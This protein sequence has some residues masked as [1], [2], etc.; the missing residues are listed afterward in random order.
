MSKYLKGW[1]MPLCLVLSTLALMQGGWWLWAPFIGT[2]L[3]FVI[4]DWILP[5]DVSEPPLFQSL[6]LNFPL[7]AI[8]PLMALMDFT[9]IW[10]AGSG[11]FL[12]YAEF[13][14]QYLGYDL[15]AARELVNDT[16]MW[17]GGVISVA[18][19]NAYAGTV[20][21]HELTHRTANP[22]D[23]FIGRWMLAFSADTQFAIEHVYGHHVTVATKEDPATARRGESFYAFTVRSTLAGWAHGFELEAQRLRKS[24]RSMLNPF[25]SPYLRGMIENGLLFYAAFLMAGWFGVGLWAAVVFIA[26]QV[27]EIANYFEHY[28]LIREEGKPVEPRHSWNSNHWMS[29]NVMFSLAR[30]SH[31]HAEA[32]WPY[33][34]LRA[35]P[36]APVLP[37]GYVTMILIAL[38]PPLFKSIM[39]PALNAWDR[40]HASPGELKLA[41]QANNDSGM[42]GL[43]TA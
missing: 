42:S 28:G 6:F 4:G 11:D 17:V 12:G 37:L 41:A 34:Q 18:T 20:A 25:A 5:H 43:V 14:K 38:F 9:L 2:T 16:W 22:F 31:H 29:S 7:Y 24:G 15:H 36:D 35:Y 23:M 27:L 13:V 32:E 33:W 26:K 10:L 30:H 1:L 19:L 39:T 40:K 8:L 3:A 21:G